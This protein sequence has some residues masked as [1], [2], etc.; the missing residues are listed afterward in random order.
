MSEAE[1][2]RL[3]E[4][5]RRRLDARCAGGRPTYYRREPSGAPA[6]LRYAEEVE[7]DVL[8]DA[9]WSPGCCVSWDCP[10]EPSGWELLAVWYRRRGAWVDIIGRLTEQQA[11]EL[12][13]QL[14]EE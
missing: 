11:T 9:S 2:R 4:Y 8:V 6:T 5:R 14:G 7:V 10:G 1:Q 13:E 3:L 12:E